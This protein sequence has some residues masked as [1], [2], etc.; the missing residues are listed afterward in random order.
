MMH[1]DLTGKRFNRLV[2]LGYSHT[3]KK[4]AYWTCKCDC[5]K[6]ATV[7]GKALK[8]NNTKSCGC[9]KNEG[10]IHFKHGHSGTPTYDSWYAMIR[11]CTNPND[12]AHPYYGGR[13]ITVCDKWLTID[14]FIE[15]MGERPYGKTLDRIDNN[16]NYELENCRWAT[17]K[18]QGNNRRSNKLITYSGITLTLSQWAERV[19][20]SSQ[21]LHSRMFVCD[22]PIEKA[23][24]APN[25]RRST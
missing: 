24:T 14:G 16:G 9:L 19:G 20:I 8:D 15:D 11:R 18:E 25:R 3:D 21:A 10:P 7:R 22:W 6:T 5:G 1:V 4:T 23:L 12:Q 13:G 2:V 17:K